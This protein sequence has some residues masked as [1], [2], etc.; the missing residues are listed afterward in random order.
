MSIDKLCRD[1]RNSADRL[2]MDFKYTSPG[3]NEQIKALSTFQHLISCWAQFLAL[4]VQKPPFLLGQQMC[5]S[6]SE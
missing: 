1:Q 2:F 3:S 6:D 4:E 5:R